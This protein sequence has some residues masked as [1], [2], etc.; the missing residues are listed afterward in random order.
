MASV[1]RSV[2]VLAGLLALTACS[3]DAS[4]TGSASAQESRPASAVST[5]ASFAAGSGTPSVAEL[6]AGTE[7]EGE[8]TIVI[9][10]WDYCTSLANLTKSDSYT[11]TES[12]SFST[13]GPVDYGPAARETNPF[14]ISAGTDP[15]EGGDVGLALQSTGVI[16]L[17]GQESDPYILQ[18][19]SLTYD[20]GHL[21]G[22][23]AEDGL[24]MGL[25]FNGFQ[26]NDTL[27][28][29]QPHQGSI[30]RPYPMQ[31]GSTIEAELSGDTASVV[32]EG[33]SHDQ[34]RRWRVEAS[35]TRVS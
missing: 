2:I 16:A 3:E 27:I 1:H 21:A 22:E 7:W 6:R 23:L 10:V 12:F 14:F 11:K 18:F 25:G 24:E 31:E 28:P 15:D 34:T 29:C 9:E 26:D 13:A 4:T 32:I 30:V 19:W 5:P 8:F 33:R 17:P 20:D 35:A